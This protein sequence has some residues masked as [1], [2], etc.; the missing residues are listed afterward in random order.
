M[1][2]NNQT[3]APTPVQD[4]NHIIAERREK[5]RIWR[6]SGK[7]FPNDFKRE[8]VAEKL[9]E[10]YG[11]QTKEE[12]EA[13]A[14][15]VT[16]AG[17]VMLKRVMGKA[18]FVTIQDLSGRLQIFVSRDAVASIE[19]N[20]EVVARCEVARLPARQVLTRAQ[21]FCYAR[22]IRSAMKGEFLAPDVESGLSVRGELTNGPKD[23]TAARRSS[24]PSS[25]ASPS[26]PSCTKRATTKAAW[27]KSPSWASTPGRWP[28]LTTR[29]STP[30][31]CASATSATRRVRAARSRRARPA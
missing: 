12:L 20:G 24:R 21:N 8:N 15:S 30:P 23:T 22:L 1:T 16:V 3:P 25:A 17:R 11:E 26:S 4:E 14:I 7:A 29:A 9:D 31:S 10:L 2:D 18:S 27:C 28:R 5:L 13:A 6:E 19:L